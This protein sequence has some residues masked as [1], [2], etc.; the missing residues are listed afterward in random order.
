MALRHAD[1]R[2]V[3][4]AINDAFKPLPVVPQPVPR[5]ELAVDLERDE[6]IGQR[7]TGQVTALAC[8]DKGRIGVA[9][10]SLGLALAALD[11]ALQHAVNR[12]GRGRFH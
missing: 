6:L 1:A 12:R 11:A 8:L 7:G 4:A 5:G 10:V 3:A 2:S 9:A